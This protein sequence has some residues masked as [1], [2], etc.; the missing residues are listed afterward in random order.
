MITL[1]LGIL[2]GVAGGYFGHDQ[3]AAL[4]TK[5]APP[6]PPPPL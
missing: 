2:V 5:A 4:I 6:A 1:I 3:I